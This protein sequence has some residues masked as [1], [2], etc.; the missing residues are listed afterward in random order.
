MFEDRTLVCEDCG[1]EFIFT[2]DEQ[3][4]YAEQDYKND[5]KRCRECRYARKAQRRENRKYFEGVCAK[6]G[7]PA[8]VP[9][10]PKDD[11]PIYC[12]ECYDM[13]RQEAEEEA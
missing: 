9:F 10:K 5:P 2:A 6:C 4:F 8:K 1:K 3:A 7:G 11:R 13:I 12:S